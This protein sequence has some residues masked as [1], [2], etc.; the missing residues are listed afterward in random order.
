MSP[1]SDCGVGE[2]TR[3]GL[4]LCF[5]RQPDALLPVNNKERTSGVII[6]CPTVK[7]VIILSERGTLINLRTLK[8]QTISNSFTQLR[9]FDINILQSQHHVSIQVPACSL[10]SI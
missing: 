6:S 10:A 3:C 2:L 7:G 1:F 4:I 8:S 9:V 5:V